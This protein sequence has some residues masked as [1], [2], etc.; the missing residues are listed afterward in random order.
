MHG[1]GIGLSPPGNSA[2]AACLFR[3]LKRHRAVKNSGICQESQNCRSIDPYGL[4][5]GRPRRRWATRRPQV[6]EQH[7][8]DFSRRLGHVDTVSAARDVD[9]TR[10]AL[11]ESRISRGL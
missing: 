9:A 1:G 4:S 5:P 8:A 7:A 10:A 6:A 3:T 2:E 11:G